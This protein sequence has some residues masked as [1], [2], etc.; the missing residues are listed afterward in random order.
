MK[1]VDNFAIAL[2][3]WVVDD[4]IAKTRRECASVIIANVIF[5]DLNLEPMYKYLPSASNVR[6]DCYPMQVLTNMTSTE[7]YQSSSSCDNAVLQRPSKR[8]QLL[9]FSEE[10]SSSSLSDMIRPSA[11]RLC[12]IELDSKTE[13]ED[14]TQKESNVNW[15]IP[16]GLQWYQHNS[17][18]DFYAA[19]LQ[20]KVEKQSK[21]QHSSVTTFIISSGKGD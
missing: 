4:G 2:V 15:G 18:G 13:V 12:R 11:V 1:W 5:R 7:D 20:R 9:S 10:S 14:D 3:L 6:K 16:L 21:L 17:N 19:S 8:Y